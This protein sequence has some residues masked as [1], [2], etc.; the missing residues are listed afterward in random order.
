MK[1]SDDKLTDWQMLFARSVINGADN[2]QDYLPQQHWDWP[3][4]TYLQKRLAEKK[5]KE[6]GGDDKT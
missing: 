6:Q 1:N 5:R 2:M 4:G 3:T